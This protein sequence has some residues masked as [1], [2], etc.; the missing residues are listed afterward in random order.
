MRWAAL[1]LPLAVLAGCWSRPKP[2]PSDLPMKYPGCNV[3]VVSF[4]ALQGR[5]VGALGY[6]RDVTPTIDSVAAEA[7]NFENATSVSSWTV[8]ASMTW[9]TGVY[10]SEHRMVNKFTLW[11]PPRTKVADLGERAPHLFTL[12]QVLKE[13]GYATGGFTGNAGVS[14]TFGFGKGFDT[15]YF[16]RGK[17]GGLDESVPRALAWVRQHKDEKFFLFLHGYDVHGQHSPSEGLDYRYVDPGYDRR[18]RGT[19]VEQEALRE[20]GLQKGRLDLREQDVRFWRAVYDEKINRA[21]ARFRQ[22]LDDLTRIGVRERTLLVL[23]SDHGT[24]AY[25]HGRFDHGFT[26]YQELVH[27]PLIVQLPGQKAG[28]NLSPRVSSIDLMPTILD[29]VGA[30]VPQAAKKQMRGE[31]LVPVL[32]GG[33]QPRDVFSETDYREYT[34]KRSIITPGGWKLIYTLE[35]GRRELYNLDEDREEANDLAGERPRLADEL[36]A[37]LFAHFRSLGHDLKKRQWKVGL[38]PVYESQGKDGVKKK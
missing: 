38:N 35:S 12:A 17:F 37:R 26:L 9:F 2:D 22:F 29:L 14:G 34:Y 16:P 32:Q 10:P 23:T 3:V 1:L 18:F 15:Y 20:E 13:N 6:H 28:K 36:E 5:H 33:E 8:P 19:E 30:E 21:D 4:D 25:E 11:Q 24:E 7:F 27:V 31:S